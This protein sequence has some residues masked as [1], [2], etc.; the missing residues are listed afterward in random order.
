MSRHPAP[1]RTCDP[2]RAQHRTAVLG[3]MACRRNGRGWRSLRK[4]FAP[5]S[6]TAHQTRWPTHASL[7][8]RGRAVEC[9]GPISDVIKKKAGRLQQMLVTR[10]VRIHHSETCTN[11]HPVCDAGEGTESPLSSCR[12]QQHPLLCAPSLILFCTISSHEAEIVPCVVVPATDHRG[13]G[14][15]AESKRHQPR[16]PSGR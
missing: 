3:A 11:S 1:A 5:P 10:S 8:D 9:C 7:P 12:A 14:I 16:L 15:Q 2:I 4:K 13:A 6:S